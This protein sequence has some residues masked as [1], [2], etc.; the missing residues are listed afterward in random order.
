MLLLGQKTG[1]EPSAS[2][3]LKLPSQAGTGGDSWGLTYLGGPGQEK[4]SNVCSVLSG[5]MSEGFRE[6]T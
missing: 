6:A 1:Q 5:M 3:F 2:S 4:S